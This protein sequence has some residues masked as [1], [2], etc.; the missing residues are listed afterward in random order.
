MG[1]GFCGFDDPDADEGNVPHGWGGEDGGGDAGG[2]VGQLEA[3]TGARASLQEE[4]QGGVEAPLSQRWGDRF[5]EKQKDAECGRHALN[6][7]LGKALFR[8]ED[9]RRTR[10]QV[11]GVERY[12]NACAIAQKGHLD[13]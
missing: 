8:H 13:D 10:E 4:M 1:F 7:V 2:D 6:N 5:F 3:A 12:P 9:L 11:G